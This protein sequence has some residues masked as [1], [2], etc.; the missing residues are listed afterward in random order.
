MKQVHFLSLLISGLVDGV[1]AIG[2]RLHIMPSCPFIGDAG[3]NLSIVQYEVAAD[4]SH[5]Q[6]RASIF[7]ELNCPERMLR[8]LS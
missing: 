3:P 5:I 2:C 4:K 7:Y 6:P 8:E 1:V